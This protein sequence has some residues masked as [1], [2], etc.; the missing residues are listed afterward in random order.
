MVRKNDADTQDTTVNAEN[1][2]TESEET[3]VVEGTTVPAPVDGLAENELRGI[4]SFS[5]VMMRYGPDG[6][7]AISD[8]LGNG[9]SLLDDKAD[10]IGTEM[11]V[12][13][14]GKHL[15]RETN[16]EFSTLHVVTTDGRKLIVNDGST[17]I[18]AQCTELVAE[19]GNVC[20]LYVGKGLRVSEYWYEDEKRGERTKARTFYLNTG[21]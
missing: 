19:R 4:E 15:D 1:E 3:P 20:P 16:R 17:G 10:L 5:D 11:I 8:V 18:H 7:T 2:K 21:K 12:V 9:F 13:K 6:V 14:Y